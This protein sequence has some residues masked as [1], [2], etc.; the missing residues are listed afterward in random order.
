M[1]APNIGGNYVLLEEE[2]LLDEYA[3]R[4]Y[5]DHYDAFTLRDKEFIKNFR[6]T[7][8]LVRYVCDAVRGDLERK[9]Y[10]RTALTVE[11]QVLIA[12]RFYGQGSHQGSVGSDVHLAVSQSSVSKAVN[13]VSKA[14]VDRLMHLISFPTTEVEKRD[15]KAGFYKMRRMP[16]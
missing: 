2:D 16:G 15:V 8:D 12:L 13:N 11:Q 7:K 3:P 1:A 6:L 14:I 5:L 10:Q 9:R 4:E